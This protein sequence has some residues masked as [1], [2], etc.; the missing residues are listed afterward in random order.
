MDE[1]VTVRPGAVVA[2]YLTAGMGLVLVGVLRETETTTGHQAVCEVCGWSHRQEHTLEQAERFE[3][4]GLH[5]PEQVL[6]ECDA[7]EIAA[8]RSEL[9]Q[10]SKAVAMDKANEHA[11]TCRMIPKGRWAAFGVVAS[12]SDP[13]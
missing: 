3:G 10:S 8:A 1:T 2:S 5:T 13:A 4:D 12:L 7:D 9:R 11:G 6:D